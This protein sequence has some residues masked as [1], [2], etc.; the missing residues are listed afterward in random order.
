MKKV[1]VAY[2]TNSGSTEDIARKVVEEL[3]KNGAHVDLN[4]LEQVTD[5]SGYDLVVIGAPMILGWHRLARKFIQQHQTTLSKT[6]VA[7]FAAAM[8]LT[9]T[10]EAQIDGVPVFV[11]SGLAKPPKNAGR[12]SFRE[13]YALPKK[14]FQPVLKSASKIKPVSIAFFGGKLEMFRLPLLQMLFV[15]LV[16]QAQP[17]DL[18]NWSAVR[19]WAANLRT[20][21][22]GTEIA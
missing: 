4:R 17:G 18:R 9:Q 22:L 21:V 3:G 2:T 1:L 13:N 14:Y 10:A 6:K 5:V 19:E 16:V 20:T 15:M 11:D 8:S 7:L 12:L